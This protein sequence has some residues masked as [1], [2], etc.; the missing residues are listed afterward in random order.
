M[1][2]LI[3]EESVKSG[4][5]SHFLILSNPFMTGKAIYLA[6]LFAVPG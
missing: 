4:N 5:Y 3:S 1:G 2:K 6:M